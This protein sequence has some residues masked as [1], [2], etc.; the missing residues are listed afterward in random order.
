MPVD[1][2]VPRSGATD[3]VTSGGDPLATHAPAGE[4][5]IRTTDYLIQSFRIAASTF[6]EV[7]ST[8]RRGARSRTDSS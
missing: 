6:R 5:W 2:Y 7:P 4:G 3:E 8:N 1:N